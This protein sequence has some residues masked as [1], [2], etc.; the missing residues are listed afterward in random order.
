MSHDGGV[1]D[2]FGCQ[3]ITL[4]DSYVCV[5]NGKDKEPC[6]LQ[7]HNVQGKKI[8]RVKRACHEWTRLLTSKPV[9]TRPLKKLQIWN[10]WKA[11][12]VEAQENMKTKKRKHE[13]LEAVEDP[14]TIS[15]TSFKRRKMVKN[16]PVIQV[17]MPKEPDSEETIE[18]I[19]ETN[20]TSFGFEFNERNVQWLRDYILKELEK[21]QKD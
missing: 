12:I 16:N 10:E 19:V 18:V 15:M 2:R 7:V 3:P 17:T 14:G 21:K 9:Y 8:V 1:H 6:A 13:S 11:A 5:W 4:D 20:H